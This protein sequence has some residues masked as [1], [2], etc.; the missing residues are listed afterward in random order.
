MKTEMIQDVLSRWGIILTPKR[1]T[2]IFYRNK[3]ISSQTKSYGELMFIKG[4]ETRIKQEERQKEELQEIEEILKKRE[5]IESEKQTK[6][7][8]MKRCWE[9]RKENPEL[10]LRKSAEK[11]GFP[12]SSGNKTFKK[13]FEEY[14]NIIDKEK[15][16]DYEDKVLRETK[17]NKM[18]RC[19]K[20]KKENSGW[21]FRKIGKKI[22]LH[23]LT[24]K[25]YIKNYEK[26]LGTKK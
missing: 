9:F 10:S 4:F 22:G 13:Y 14:Q 19:G 18:K 23:H 6:L 20:L 12:S 24:V 16:T 8:K 26:E 2:E 21:S 25:K 11:L 3:K 17:I 7:D 5:K 15:D 1:I